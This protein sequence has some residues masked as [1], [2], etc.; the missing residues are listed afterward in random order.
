[1]GC[2]NG[3]WGFSDS[4]EASFSGFQ[5]TQFVASNTTGC[6]F[7]WFVCRYFSDCWLIS[8]QYV[9]RNM[10]NFYQ[11]VFEQTQFVT[12]SFTWQTGKSTFLIRKSSKHRGKLSRTK[13][14][15]VTFR[16]RSGAGHQEWKIVQRRSK[17]GV[18]I[19]PPIIIR[20]FFS[21]AAHSL[22]Y[23]W[24]GRIWGILHGRTGFSTWNL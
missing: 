8:W 21:Q 22:V 12:C 7:F 2:L 13:R 15:N 5:P 19:K 16:A 6:G 11:W 1:M 3:F 4:T 14:F 18:K 9:S 20:S 24:C 10:N 23:V 17:N